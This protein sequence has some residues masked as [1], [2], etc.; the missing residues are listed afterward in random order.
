MKVS[1]QVAGCLFLIVLC[2][3]V[4]QAKSWHGITPLRSTREDVARALN[5]PIDETKRRF[6]NA[7]ATETIDFLFA[8]TEDYVEDCVKKLPVGT[9]LLIEITPGTQVRLNELGLDEN[10]LKELKSSADFLIDGQAYWDDTEGVVV[11][12]TDGFVRKI[13]YIAASQDRYLCPTYY[14]EPR[15]FTERIV[16][17]LCPTVAV[18]CPD[19]TEAGTAITFT[20]NTAV[21]N[22]APKLTFYWTVTA[23]TIMDGQGTERIK[24]DTK[25][26][27]GKTITATVKVDGF[28]P[29][30]NNTA[31]CSTP[32]VSRKKLIP[33]DQPSPQHIQR[34]LRGAP[35]NQFPVAGNH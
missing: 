14:E 16:C 7:S 13:V 30:C 32:I 12:V 33:S 2:S 20:A 31:S 28:D 3:A 10:K 34:R 21:G 35:A 4:A 1:T 9:V 5:F 25:N 24:V 8:G 17:R 18:T 6:T 19:D 11:T 29:A 26:L 23:G 15:L 22:P 27:G